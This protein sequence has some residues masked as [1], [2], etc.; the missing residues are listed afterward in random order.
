[1]RWLLLPALAYID[2]LPARL[3]AWVPARA[4]GTFSQTQAG[5]FAP[6]SSALQWPVARLIAALG[7]FPDHL[8]PPMHPPESPRS[9]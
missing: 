1:M 8:G 7:A 5:H 4:D 2:A 9:P 3:I 6:D